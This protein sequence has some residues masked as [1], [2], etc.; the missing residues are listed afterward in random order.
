LSSP[1]RL[2][3]RPAHVPF[4]PDGIL[5]PEKHTM[6]HRDEQPLASREGRKWGEE[7]FAAEVVV[8]GPPPGRRFGFG[9]RVAKWGW[10]LGLLGVL[11]CGL[12]V[13]NLWSSAGRIG[14]GTVAPLMI[15]AVALATGALSALLALIALARRFSPRLL[16]H[17]LAGMLAN[18]LCLLALFTSGVLVLGAHSAR[19]TQQRRLVVRDDF[20]Q[21]LG[22][23]GPRPGPRTGRSSSPS[24]RQ[25]SP[26]PRPLTLQEA[27]AQNRADLVQ[28]FIDQGEDLNH[29]YRDGQ[30]L[31]IRATT[32]GNEQVAA[33]LLEHGA[34]ANGNP[35]KKLFPLC[36]A[37]QQ[38]RVE[39]ARLLLRYDP[40]VHAVDTSGYDALQHAAKRGLDDI[41]GELLAR[42]ADANRLSR[43]EGT[44]LRI[45][46]EAG[47]QETVRVLLEHGAD[48]NV[49]DEG[50][51]TVL[52][53]AICRGRTELAKLLV[54]HGAD[55]NAMTRRVASPLY[56]AIARKNI[57]MVR[58]LLEHGA[59]P[60]LGSV[61]ETPQAAAV[62]YSHPE[63]TRLLSD[64]RENRGRNNEGDAAATSIAGPPSDG[65]QETLTQQWERLFGPGQKN[66]FLVAAVEDGNCDLVKGLLEAG[67][68]PNAPNKLKESLVTVLSRP[69]LRPAQQRRRSGARGK[70][71]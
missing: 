44:A 4:A 7:I 63:I 67:A 18:A 20:E 51:S 24:A 70:T 25:S 12:S 30:T 60:H 10:I 35:E 33:L 68:D 15:A 42:G 48:P 26:T 6:Q 57:E 2:D 5:Q 61:R 14:S 9:E 41:V 21:Q 62:R 40:D 66:D 52:H 53:L 71:E 34:D 28:R 16:G 38:R 32:R 45:A 56:E 69:W 36:L 54:D 46:T 58:Y 55:V 1:H 27:V 22:D 23:R 17:L 8:G 65:P 47:H 3:D 31:L 49:G 59:D 50:R 19:Q 37:V 13:L 29:V 11:L 43:R 39:L 64:Y